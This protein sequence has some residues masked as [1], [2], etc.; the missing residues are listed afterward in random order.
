MTHDW[1]DPAGR[2][3][4]DLCDAVA[5]VRLARGDKM[6]ALDPAML[7]AIIAAI[8]ALSRMAGIRAV[9]LSGEGRAFCAGLDM[10]S[11]ADVGAVGGADLNARTHGLANRFQQVAWGWRTL[12]MPVIAAIHGI[13]FGGGC[14]IMAGADLRIAHPDTRI[15][16]MEAKWGL[17]PDMA[18]MALWRGLVRD[19]W[20]RELAYTAREID[21]A[22]AVANGLVSRLADDPH[23][24][25]MTLAR[26]IAA[27]SPDAVRG[28]KRLAN[29]MADADAAALLLAESA[30][31]QQ[32]MR[33]ANQIEAVMANFEKR[34]P[35]FT[36]PDVLA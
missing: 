4:I 9:V 14:Q 5:D 16:I 20:L 10:A 13:A 21:G 26:T 22:E 36:D 3:T 25:A 19:D 17:V 35:R 12:P 23:G 24:A 7:D 32:I 1:T 8:D 29:A 27:R 30:E 18:G 34:L 33:T 28:T 2:V 6:N 11:M 31:Q 15:A